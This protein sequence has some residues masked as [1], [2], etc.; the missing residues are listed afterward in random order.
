V[1]AVTRVRSS[2]GREA[3]HGAFGGLEV[4]RL[5]F[6]PSFRHGTVDPSRGYV[7]FVL[8]GAVCKSFRGS[9]AT[10][11]GGSFMSIPAGEAHSSAFGTDGCTVLVIRPA[12]DEE[13]VFGALLARRTHARAAASLFLARQLT[14]ELERPDAY[15]ELAVEGLALELLARAGRTVAR[16]DSGSQGW[17]E[18]VLELIHA[19]SP[20]V[21]SLNELGAAVDRHPAHVA[22]AFRRAHG[23]SVTA[24]VRSVRLEWATGAVESTNDSLARVALDAGFADQSHFT[25]WFK[26]HHGVTPGRYRELLR[27]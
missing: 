15:S 12:S 23:V 19:S 13:R 26:R 22:R 9:S 14:S 1:K 11:A 5:F 8:E 7:A 16:H 3:S 18:V 4:F 10:L 21:P 6:P 24:Y 17:L 25:R 2:D 20:R 27:H